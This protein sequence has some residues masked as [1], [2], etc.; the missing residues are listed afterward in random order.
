MEAG[1]HVGKIVLRMP[2]EPEAKKSRRQDMKSRN[3]VL[4]RWR[5]A[6]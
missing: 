1:A 2:A 3:L 6:H 5:S 4:A